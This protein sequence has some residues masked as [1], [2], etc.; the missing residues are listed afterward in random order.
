MDSIQF[1][2]G[3]ANPRPREMTS[4]EYDTN[5]IPAVDNSAFATLDLGYVGVHDPTL[6][7]MKLSLV[8]TDVT[9]V[10][11]NPCITVTDG[12]SQDSQH[13]GDLTVTGAAGSYCPTSIGTHNT[14]YCAQIG[15]IP[16]ADSLTTDASIAVCYKA[17]GGGADGLWTDSY[18]RLKV[19]KLGYLDHYVG[20]YHD[21]GYTPGELIRHRTAGHLPAVGDVSVSSVTGGFNYDLLYKGTLSA[22]AQVSFVAAD[23]NDVV[24]NGATYQRPCQAAYAGRSASD[25]PTQTTGILTAQGTD[26][27]GED[28]TSTY[29]AGSIGTITNFVST[30]LNAQKVFA[31]CYSTDSFASDSHDSGLRF[32]ISKIQNMVFD[33]DTSDHNHSPSR[34]NTPLFLSTNRIPAW[35]N[36]QFRCWSQ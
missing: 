23:W 15:D 17:T 30:N 4:V 33:G 28:G 27:T 10:N 22:T 3:Y 24:E 2:S 21:S 12:E 8:A 13:T 11:G 32:T 29:T 31:L 25:Y 18:I 35:S 34:S 7:S 1:N 26:G 36:R 19:T 20:R 6:G 5:R 16:N 9:L 14:P